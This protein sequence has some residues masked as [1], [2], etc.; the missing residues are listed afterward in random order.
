[1]QGASRMLPASALRNRKCL[2]VLS[3]RERN[4]HAQFQSKQLVA[5]YA[6]TSYS[7]CLFLFRLFGHSALREASNASSLCEFCYMC[8]HTMRPCRN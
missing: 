7:V 4:E 1:M 6:V 3:S 5:R 2:K 8:M